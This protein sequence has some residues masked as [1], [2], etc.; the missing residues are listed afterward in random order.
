MSA[1]PTVEPF[2]AQLSLRPLSETI[3]K[4]SRR[5]SAQVSAVITEMDLPETMG[6]ILKLADESLVSGTWKQYV[7]NAINENVAGERNVKDSLLYSGISARLP[8]KL[9]MLTMAESQHGKTFLET[10]TG[11]VLFPSIFEDITEI[12]PKAM[13]YEIR[14][15]RNPRLYDGRIVMIDELNDMSEMLRQFVKKATTNDRKRLTLKTVEDQKYREMTIE[16]LPVVWTNTYELVEDA[17]NQLH[18]RF[19]KVNH[20]NTDEQGYAIETMQQE[21]STFGRR[22]DESP[23]VSAARHIIKK[24]MDLDNLQP[25]RPLVLNPFGRHICETEHGR[26]NRRPMLDA[27]IS[28]IAYANRFQSTTFEDDETL[29]VLTSMADI[30][31]GMAIYEAN[32]E[33]Q[34]TS[35]PEYLTRF[36]KL[37]EPEEWLTKVELSART[38]KKWGEAMSAES[39]YVY[40]HDLEKKNLLTSRK[41]TDYMSGLETR[42]FEYTPLSLNNSKTFILDTNFANRELLAKTVKQQIERSLKSFTEMRESGIAAIV[43]RL[44]TK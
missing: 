35:T 8:T 33:A 37:F 27:L 32:E 43:D 2:R 16:G 23:A 19:F 24:I 7:D 25:K 15:K 34:R 17:G 30:R 42:T 39:C 29:L 9:H 36:L 3:S 18:N 6:D 21:Q 11:M 13:Y 38:E 26:R 1:K 10:Q 44:L 12:S 28:A 31:A 5:H 4:N 14:E 20:E 40:A 41:R 22:C